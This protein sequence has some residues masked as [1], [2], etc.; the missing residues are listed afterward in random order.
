EPCEAR[1]DL[2]RDPPRGEAVILAG[3]HRVERLRLDRYLVAD[4]R[5]FPREPLADPRLAAT[6]AV[7]VG[8]V[9]RPDAE[10]PARIQDP[11]RSP[12]RD[13][14]SE[15]GGCRADTAEIPAAEDDPRDR[16]PAPT[17]LPRLHLR[18][19]GGGYGRSHNKARQ[20]EHAEKW[21]ECADDE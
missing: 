15:E 12:P 21:P 7:G 11:R 4:G 3:V 9:E 2:P 20:H 17:E 13:P 5:P 6:A 1:L 19:L 14:L 10:I 18:R 16:D 8:G